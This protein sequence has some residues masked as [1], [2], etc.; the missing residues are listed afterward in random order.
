LDDA[1]SITEDD[2][3]AEFNVLINDTR[4]VDNESFKLTS[5]GSV[6]QGGAAR[7]S[8]DG[9]QFFYAPAANFNGTERVTYTIQDTGGG[10]AVGTVTFTVAAV[11]DPPP[12]P[13]ITFPS[14]RGAGEVV[15]VDLNQLANVDSGESISFSTFSAATT[16]GGSVRQDTASGRLFYTPP[17]ADFTGSDS[18]TYT[19]SDG[20]GLT[21]TGTVS[22]EVSD[23]QTRT[24]SY[25]FASSP[26]VLDANAFRLTGTNAL[27]E[28]VNV[29]ATLNGDSYDFA[30][31]LPGEYAIEIP[32]IPFLQNG[33]EPKSIAISSLPEDGDMAIQSD[34]GRLRPEFISIRDFLRSTPRKSILVAVAP[35]QTSV[36]ATP[37]SA[38]DA[39]T[40][41]VVELDSTGNNLTIRG[42]RVT[43]ANPTA[44]PPTV[45]TTENVQAS[46]T[47]SGNANVQQRGEINGLKLFKI[48]VE[49][50]AVTFTAPT[51]TTA[52]VGST[53]P[54]SAA[55]TTSNTLEIGNTAAEGESLASASAVQA[56]IFS[57]APNPATMSGN[58]ESEITVDPES[59]IEFQTSPSLVSNESPND[60]AMQSV[61]NEL[62]LQSLT[63]DAIAQPRSISEDN[64]DGL[65]SGIE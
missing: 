28:T 29:P 62:K 14:N 46:L 59:T 56:D 58:D 34:L 57:P 36:L 22:I 5:I 15:V 17:S 13:D 19:V 32:A 41:P 30:D 2:A 55:A 16:A 49:E 38:V 3:E 33:S 21:A 9:T 10:V 50:S 12:A 39:V 35:G 25:N 61:A 45:E 63:E 40:R 7:V 26:H 65:L 53:T 48:S 44:N 60:V 27:G 11:N 20:N 37:S 54:A 23:F 52:N 31:V 4:D 64:V 6:S 51:V 18:F 43:P 47:T 1:F 24:F 42:T 8:A